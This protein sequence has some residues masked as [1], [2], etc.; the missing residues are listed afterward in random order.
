MFDRLVRHPTFGLLPL[1]L[2]LLLI[3]RF[4]IPAYAQS[5]PQVAPQER[6]VLILH[7]LETG[8]VGMRNQF[9]EYLDL[10]RHPDGI[11]THPWV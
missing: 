8:G 2:L 6:N 7:A 9:Y 4:S 10:Q 1:V 11:G 3:S 5:P